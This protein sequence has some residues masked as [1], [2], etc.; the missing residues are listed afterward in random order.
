MVVSEVPH[1]LNPC[2]SAQLKIRQRTLE[3]LYCYMAITRHGIMKRTAIA[4]L[5]GSLC[6]GCRTQ[7]PKIVS[8]VDQHGI[9]GQYHFSTA[10]LRIDL[11]FRADG[12]YHASMDSWAHVTEEHGVWQTEA[13]NIVLS[14]RFGGL[15][16]SIRRLGPVP[17]S[18]AGRLQKVGPDSQI[19]RAIMF[20]KS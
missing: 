3:H 9:A 1:I 16:M 10:D 13:D 7:A 6:A 5:A 4:L 15:Q 11:D 12:T 8:A 20:S 17:Q 2:A 18:P 14:P 19:G